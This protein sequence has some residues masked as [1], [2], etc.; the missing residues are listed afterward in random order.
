MKLLI[1]AALSCSFCFGQQVVLYT[2]SGSASGRALIQNF[3]SP[4]Q[5][6]LNRFTTGA[7][8][9]GESFSPAHPGQIL[10]AW[11]SGFGKASEVRVLLDDRTISPLYAGPAPGGAGIDQLNFQL[12][13]DLKP[14]CIV[15]LQIWADGRL[16]NSASVA[17]AS[18]GSGACEHPTLSRA[19]LRKLDTGEDIVVGTVH[20]GTLGDG[21]LTD[22][23][24][25]LAYQFTNDVGK[26]TFARYSADDLDRMQDFVV[27]LDKCRTFEGLPI[28]NGDT[29]D[30]RVPRTLDAG[31]QLNI[32][33]LNWI[34]F[35]GAIT[36]Q[37]RYGSG[38]E[39]LGYGNAVW[40]SRMPSRLTLSSDGGTEIAAF[41]VS[42][43]LPSVAVSPPDSPIHRSRA[44]DATKGA[45]IRWSPLSGGIVSAVLTVSNPPRP[46]TLVCTAASES[47]SISIPPRFLE[48]AEFSTLQ[49]LS[50]KRVETD[51]SLSL[52]GGGQTDAINVYNLMG[53][54][55]YINK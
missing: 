11:G 43:S 30:L 1:F 41:Q 25:Q 40:N 47:G 49:L 7:N 3:I 42:V 48:R 21:D 18:V 13:E 4:T 37:Y 38:V 23:P 24:P 52:R 20:V 32:P 45:T 17:V 26:A 29:G 53:W 6:D 28:Y 14:G 50:L 31:S 12:P 19:L 9:T 44:I 51:S 2:V 16:S 46:R 36:G 5:V 35:K 39:E 8:S 10:V 55:W 22:Y 54:G 15:P 33:E 27:E 34:L